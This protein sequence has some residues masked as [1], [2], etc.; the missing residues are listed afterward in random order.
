MAEDPKS[1]APPSCLPAQTSCLEAQPEH[2][3]TDPVVV[4][5]LLNGA[6]GDRVVSQGGVP[7]LHRD[8]WPCATPS[9]EAAQSSTRQALS[10]RGK[11]TFPMVQS[12]SF[13]ALALAATPHMQGTCCLVGWGVGGVLME[14]AWQGVRELLGQVF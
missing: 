1:L 8:T 6:C 13:H 7:G 11:S 4:W 9:A 2:A 3:A 12:L 10:G 5:E 14:G